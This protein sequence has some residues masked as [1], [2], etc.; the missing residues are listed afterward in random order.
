MRIIKLILTLAILYGIYIYSEDVL[1]L[2]K[3]Y[4]PNVLNSSISF[5]KNSIS[6]AQIGLDGSIEDSVSEIG[7]LSTPGALIVDPGSISTKTKGE[8]TIASIIESTNNARVENNLPALKENSLLNS[9][10]LFKTNDMLKRQYFEHDSPDGRGISDLVSDV[11]YEYITVGENLAMGP[12]TTGQEIVDAWMNSPGHRANILQTKYTEIGI[13]IV[14]GT[15]QGKKVWMAVQHFGNPRS[16]CPSIDEKLKT[17]IDTLKKDVEILDIDLKSLQSII[18]KHTPSSS[19]VSVAS[20]ITTYNQ[21]AS[22]YNTLSKTI[23]QAVDTYNN[24]VKA[25]NNCVEVK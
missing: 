7:F 16:N 1:R 8:L 13:G 21:K 10:A 12:F 3:K 23:K 14:E 17:Q 2:F 15:Y 11:K 18:S 6:K 19:G 9:S 20:I 25:F 24:Q 5:V 22:E 4:G